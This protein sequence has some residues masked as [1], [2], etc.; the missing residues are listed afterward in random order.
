MYRTNK[1]TP[2][3]AGFTL[4]ELAIVLVIIGLLVGGVLTGAD[5]IKSAQLYALNQDKENVV[6]A[7]MTFRDKY[8]RL[9]GDWMHATDT[10]GI[11]AGTGSDLTCQNTPT[12]A[13][14]TATC[15]GNGDGFVFTSVAAHDEALRFYQQLGAAGLIKGQYTGTKGTAS[16]YASNWVSGVTMPETHRTAV[17]LRTDYSTGAAGDAANFASPPG[18][19]LE[20]VYGPAVAGVA[21]NA[22]IFTPEEALRM[23]TKYDDGLPATGTIFNNKGRRH[24]ELL[25]QQGR[26][27]AAGRCRRDLQSQRQQP[28][29]YYLLYE[30]VLVERRRCAAGPLH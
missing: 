23:D 5:L 15:N 25:H 2:R 1:G 16:G 22:L 10:F 17:G 9:P 21:Q 3:R 13:G 18:Q 11:L 28:G 24:H 20:F 30:S 7:V 4:V 8:G 19:Y 6:A 27:R 12:P 26:C 14:S 29:L